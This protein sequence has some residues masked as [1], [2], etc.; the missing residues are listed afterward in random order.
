MTWTF[1]VIFLRWSLVGRVCFYRVFTVIE[2]T[3]GLKA[4]SGKNSKLP[5]LFDIKV[6]MHC[7]SVLPDTS[8]LSNA[9]L[10]WISSLLWA[11]CHSFFLYTI[12]IL[13]PCYIKLSQGPLR[14]I[15]M[16]ILSVN[17][18]PACQFSHLKKL[19]IY[20]TRVIKMM[21]FSSHPSR[22]SCWFGQCGAC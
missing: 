22:S 15:S 7:S 4:L 8:N 21:Y 6:E 14:L 19:P 10:N 3:Q 1:Q 2:L 18:F 12:W 16:I 17:I 11:F 20:W 5:F 13:C 9:A